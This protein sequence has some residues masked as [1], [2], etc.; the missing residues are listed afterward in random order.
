[1][2]VK[3]IEVDVDVNYRA[4]HACRVARDRSGPVPR[5][6][7][8]TALS[9]TTLGMFTASLDASIVL[10]SLPAIFRGINL[11][12]LTP[13]NIGYL[14]WML[15]GYLVATAVLVVTFGRLGDMFGRVRVGG[16]LLAAA[17]FFFL[18]LL[19][20]NFSFP[21]FALLLLMNGI[22]MGLFAAPNVTGIMNSVPPGQRGAASGMRATFQNTGMV[23]S[24]GLFFSLMIVGLSSTLPTTLRNGLVTNGVAPAKA[25][26]IA[27][28]PPV[29]SLFASFLGYNPM[30]KLVGEQTLSQLPP[31]NAA[32]ITGRQFFP[33]LISQP[34][35]DG[36]R[37]AFSASM[38]MCL[39]AAW[40]SWLRGGRY[41]AEEEGAGPFGAPEDISVAAADEAPVPEEWVPA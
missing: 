6:Y 13:S 24:I 38:L 28:E 17:S 10:I 2:H 12:P 36:L 40:A 16:M 23:L 31:Q 8:W 30:E 34:F 39:I 37:I 25:E 35:S 26:Q 29:G 1:V 33:E 22:G 20:A 14:L 9:N 41:F 19:P 32:N 7:K 3:N 5:N 15:M 11:D 18:T 4:R 21:V 27:N